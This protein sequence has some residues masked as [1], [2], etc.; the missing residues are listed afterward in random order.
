MLNPKLLVFL[1]FSISLVSFITLTITIRSLPRQPGSRARPA[2]IQQPETPPPNN[3]SYLDPF[4]AETN[5]IIQQLCVFFISWLCPTNVALVLSLAD[6]GRE[7]IQFN[8]FR[9]ALF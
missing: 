6:L 8:P 5:C 9:L 4:F 7:F 3:Q 1:S 2:T